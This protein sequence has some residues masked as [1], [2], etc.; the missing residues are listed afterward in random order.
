[1]DYQVT[2]VRGD[3]GEQFTFDCDP[4]SR[5]LYKFKRA[6]TGL[7]RLCSAHGLVI[8]FLTLTL[9]GEDVNTQN[10]DL[11]K[12]FNWL[13]NRFSR[14]HVEMWYLWVVELQKKR[15]ARTGV[16]ALHWHIAIAVPEDALPHVG[17]DDNTG[18]LV[19]LSGGYLV[20]FAELEKFWGRGFVWCQVSKSNVFNYLKKYLVKDYGAFA[21]YNP[22]WSNLRRFGSSQLKLY[23]S[24][25]WVFENVKHLADDKR[26]RVKR[27][28]GR[29]V[30][31]RRDDTVP[32]DYEFASWASPYAV[33]AGGRPVS[34]SSRVVD[35]DTE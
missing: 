23:A 17:W 35:N 8:Y 18:E 26:W 16:P 2:L 5:S 6:A 15:Y 21:D 1:M 4:A 29:A 12:F 25:A 30:L 13:R 11:N 31:L 27:R 14:R 32:S 10:K 20:S 24:P 33:I 9:R 7:S 28:A 22:A 3:T 34:F 19:T